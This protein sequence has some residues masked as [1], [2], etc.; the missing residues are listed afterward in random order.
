[1]ETGGDDLK[2]MIGPGQLDVGNVDA[3]AAQFVA[4]EVFEIERDD[5]I[6]SGHYHQNGRH[7]GMDDVSR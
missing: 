6:A 3:I 7:S 5:V 1:V 2:G 4:Q